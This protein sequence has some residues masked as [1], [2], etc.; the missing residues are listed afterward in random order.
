[1]T[2]INFTAT[3]KNVP[4]GYSLGGTDLFLLASDNSINSTVTDLAGTAVGEWVYLQGT[5]IDDGWYEV[6]LPSG[7]NKIVLDAAFTDDP[8]GPNMTMVG[9]YHEPGASLDIEIDPTVLDQSTDVVTR[10][11]ESLSGI[12]DTLLHRQVDYWNVTTGF[13]TAAEMP[14]WLEFLA[15]VAAGAQFI[16]DPYG[17][18]AVPV[19]PVNCVM[20][21]RRPFA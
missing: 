17:S 21:G 20:V 16:F 8:A 9:Y 3:K 1:M 18:V 7:A 2:A 4:T 19:D 14:Y 5:T 6:L 15:S 12:K 11:S 10:T 13:I